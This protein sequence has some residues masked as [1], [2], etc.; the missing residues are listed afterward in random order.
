MFER[1]KQFIPCTARQLE[2]GHV[3]CTTSTKFNNIYMCI[4]AVHIDNA[5]RIFYVILNEC[6]KGVS[7]YA[8]NNRLTFQLLPEFLHEDFW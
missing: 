6:E 8:C 2:P 7:D 3:F 1:T 5:V 4:A